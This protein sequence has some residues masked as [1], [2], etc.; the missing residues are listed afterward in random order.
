MTVRE[1]RQLLAQS[2][3]VTIYPLGLYGTG[4]VYFKGSAADIPKILFDKQVFSI[5]PISR[6][7]QGIPRV[8]QGISIEVDENLLTKLN[9][10]N[11]EDVQ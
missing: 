10:L 1:I 6:F 3:V 7:E 11:K 2:I 4:H 9:K 5:L 8:E